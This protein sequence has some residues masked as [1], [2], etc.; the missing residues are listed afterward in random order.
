MSLSEHSI[1]SEVQDNKQK[2][3]LNKKEDSVSV[4]LMTY[5]RFIGFSKANY[6]LFPLTILL[7]LSTEAINTTYFRLLANYDA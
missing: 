6:F 1:I 3:S 7:Y 4:S 5:F 2:I